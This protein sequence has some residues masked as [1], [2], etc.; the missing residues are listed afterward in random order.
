MRC[1]VCTFLKDVLDV[2]GLLLYFIIVHMMFYCCMSLCDVRLSHLNKDY[3]LTSTRHAC[4]C[5]C[6]LYTYI[7]YGT[8]VYLLTYAD[9]NRV[10]ITIIRLCV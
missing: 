4:L 6:S 10:S 2:L 9:G 8:L 7:L 5:R 1:F 3:L